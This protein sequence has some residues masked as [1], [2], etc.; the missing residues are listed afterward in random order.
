MQ[1]YKNFW[2]DE[3]TRVLKLG[4]YLL[5][6]VHGNARMSASLRNGGNLSLDNL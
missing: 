1:L 2:I 4:G 3:L 6:T 5:I